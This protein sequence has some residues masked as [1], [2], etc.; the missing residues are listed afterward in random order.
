MQKTVLK[1]GFLS[2]ALCS[3]LMALS[4]VFA[5]RIG[6]GHSMYVGYTIMV[7]SFLLVYFGVRSYRNEERAGF[8]TFGR[9]F[10]VGISIMLITCLC[11]VVMWEIMYHFFMPDFFDNYSAYVMEKA[12]AAGASAGA[13]DAKAAQLRHAKELYA[14]PFYNAAMTFLE[15]LPVGLLMTL[16][17]AVILRKSPQRQSAAAVSR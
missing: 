8:I 1:F 5:H 13:L 7:V 9:A 12:R 2:G 11:Y 6:Y 15:P 17:S 3:G 16:I 10:G 4:L 14:N